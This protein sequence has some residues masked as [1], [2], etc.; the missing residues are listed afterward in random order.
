MKN[1]SQIMMKD[2]VLS[3]VEQGYPLSLFVF[4][5]TGGFSQCI[6]AVQEVKGIQKGKE[7]KLSL[8]MNDLMIFAENP[9]NLK[10]ATRTNNYI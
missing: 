7:V 8:F 3:P 4:N 5:H 1:Y 9:K 6:K 10:N 2:W